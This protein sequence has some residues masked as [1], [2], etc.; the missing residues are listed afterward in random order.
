MQDIDTMTEICVTYTL[1]INAARRY[2]RPFIFVAWLSTAPL[3]LYFHIGSALIV[4]VM[5]V[6][7]GLFLWLLRACLI[8]TMRQTRPSDY[9]VWYIVLSLVTRHPLDA[10]RVRPLMESKDHELQQRAGCYARLSDHWRQEALS[11]QTIWTF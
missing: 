4:P 7:S 1:E 6:A 5:L 8:L 11:M 9:I 10:Q 3:S 2:L